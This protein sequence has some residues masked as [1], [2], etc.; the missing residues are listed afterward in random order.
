MVRNFY[1]VTA[2]SNLPNNSYLKT[3][4]VLLELLHGQENY[5]KSQTESYYER[6]EY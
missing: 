6:G 3:S 1:F 5:F 4:V 2:A